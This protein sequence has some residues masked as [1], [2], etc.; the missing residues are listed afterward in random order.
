MRPGN[1][2]KISQMT[3]N[4]MKSGDVKKAFRG[5]PGAPYYGFR[6]RC[7]RDWSG[8]LCGRSVNEASKDTA[9]SPTAEPKAETERPDMN[10]RNSETQNLRTGGT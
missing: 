2:G 8:I 1:R 9:E 5:C 3:E 6:P 7:V 10:L 4:T